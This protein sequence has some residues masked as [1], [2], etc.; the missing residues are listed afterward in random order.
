MRAILICLMLGG[1]AAAPSI[2]EVSGSAGGDVNVYRQAAGLPVLTTSAA[3]RRAAE[4]HAA[5]MARAGFFSHDGSDGSTMA[6]RLRAVGCTGGAENI[7]AGPY[8]RVT[9]LE[10]WMDSPAHRANILNPAMRTYG[11][12]QSG[13]RW[14]MVLGMDC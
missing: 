1:C 9:V 7:A 14:V 4:R 12:A 2:P 5:D 11:V 8:D 3:T 6:D 13:D 10:A